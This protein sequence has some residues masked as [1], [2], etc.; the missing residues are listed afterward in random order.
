[1]SLDSSEYTLT[2]LAN[3]PGDDD[4]GGRPS[5]NYEFIMQILSKSLE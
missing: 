3:T 4:I 5:S 2:I 1:M